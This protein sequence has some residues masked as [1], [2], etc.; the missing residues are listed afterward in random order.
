M[1]SPLV[2]IGI[3]FFNNKNTL[4][5]AIRSVFSQT[6]E[7]WELILIDDGS[8][9]GS[10]EFAG[11]ITDSRV[12]VLSDGKNLKL[13]TRL[14]EIARLAKGKLIARMDADDIMHPDRIEN[15]VNYFEM[16]PETDVTGTSAYIISDQGQILGKREGMYSNIQA[17]SVIQ[18][19]PYIHPTVM[20]RTKWFRENPYNEGDWIHRAQDKELWIR[21]FC[22]TCHG[23]INKPLLYYREIGNFNIRKYL[24][25]KITNCRILKNYGP[26]LIGYPKTLTLAFREIFKVC[27]YWTAS[28]LTFQNHLIMKR[29][30][31]LTTEQMVEARKALQKAI[32]STIPCIDMKSKELGV[33]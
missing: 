4:A 27:F 24:M 1:S 23:Y 10:A 15:Q 12:T 19:V 28:V 25:S 11:R 13:S 9:D 3:P 14:N 30:S 21:T 32:N 16:H 6:Y 8:T 22:N 31:P 5:D 7:N 29:S 33:Q 17:S 26:S 20:G 18:Q 2:T